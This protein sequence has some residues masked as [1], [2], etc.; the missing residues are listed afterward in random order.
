MDYNG[1]SI[2]SNG[3]YSTWSGSGVAVATNI[4]YSSQ[5]N[6]AYIG[7]PLPTE[8]HAGVL[9]FSE[10][11]LTNSI[12]GTPIPTG[13]MGIDTMV[14]PTFMQEL[15]ADA[16]V[17]NANLRIAFTTN[18]NLAVYHG[19]L[20]DYW[21]RGPTPDGSTWTIFTNVPAVASGKWARVSIDVSYAADSDV[22][23]LCV[24]FKVRVDGITATDP[25]G[26]PT[27]FLPSA[28]T[29]G[30]WFLASSW[31]T[32]NMNRLILN[33][34]GMLDDLAINSDAIASYVTST[35][36]I[37]Y[38]WLQ[39]MGVTNDTSTS[40]MEAADTGTADADA[41]GMPN[42]AEYIAGTHPTNA[43]SRLIIVSE[44]MSNGIPR[45]RWLSSTNALAPYRIDATTNLL[46]G[47]AGW[48]NQAAGLTYDVS[49]NGTNQYDMPTP[50]SSPTFYRIT[51]IK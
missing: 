32:Y 6:T 19:T 37:P 22:G 42:W 39:A 51:I 49:G 43:L 50:S 24:M 36:H 26:Y 9:S 3:T 34:S 8:G 38:G 7:Y 4:D 11:P 44:V 45:V 31:T 29:G 41:D 18:G 14:Q 15:V 21:N 28:P 33:G 46:A 1:Q 27:A 13:V 23:G 5:L 16:A 10:A 48:T 25:S 20:T 2:F 17:S 12:T 30:P 47:S 40:A 35:H